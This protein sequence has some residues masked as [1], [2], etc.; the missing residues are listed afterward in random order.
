MGR[1][2]YQTCHFFTGL[3]FERKSPMRIFRGAIAPATGRLTIL[4]PL[5]LAGLI[6]ASDAQYNWTGTGGNNKWSNASNWDISG[7]PSSSADTTLDFFGT[8]TSADNDISDPFT[9]NS[10]S[11]DVTS[12]VF[13]VSGGALNFVTDSSSDLPTLNQNSK[14]AI[15]ISNN[16]TLTDSLTL[17]GPGTGTVTLS[18]VI[19]GP[20]SLI[21]SANA[22]VNPNTWVA[23]TPD[24]G[25]FTTIISNSGNTYSGGTYIAGGVVKLGADNALP[26]A[27][28][29]NVD[30]TVAGTEADSTLDLNG[31]NQTVNNINLGDVVN[32][33]SLYATTIM[34]S[35][36]GSKGTLTLNGNIQFDGG[37]QT[38]AP[39][40]VIS[41]N[42]ALSSGL[43]DITNPN[44]DVGQTGYDVVISGL[45][46]GAG[47]LTTTGGTIVAL[48]HASNQF[49]G[50]VD[51]ENSTL[52]LDAANTVSTK[53]AV[54]IGPGGDLYL[55][56]PNDSTP[57]TGTTFGSGF[58]QSIGSLTSGPHSAGLGPT[59]DLYLGAAVLTIGS[60]NTNTTF[61]G[62]ISDNDGETSDP[63]VVGGSIV[64]VGTGTLTLSGA[65]SNPNDNSDPYT[66]STTVQNGTLEVGAA[67]A[68][69]PTTS[70]IM[71]G[72]SFLTG[73]FSDT[74]GNITNGSATNSGGNVVISSGG[75]LTASNVTNT[76]GNLVVVGGG[77]LTV[78]G[79]YAQSGGVSQ[80]DGKLTLRNS[81]TLLLT[82]G[83]LAGT[84]SIVS[85]VAT[86]SVTINNTQGLVNPGDLLAVSV[87]STGSVTTSAVS[88]PGTLT[89]KGNY[90][91]GANGTLQIDLGGTAQG[92]SY[93]LLSVLDKASLAGTLNVNLTNNFAPTVGETFDFLTYG[94]LAS[95]TFANIDS[96]DAG[97]TYD[98]SYNTTTKV[99]ILTV[100]TVGVPESSTLISAGLMFGSGCLVFLS[101][102]RK[103]RSRMS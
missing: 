50:V 47:G 68:L 102:R 101:R 61:N 51:V 32:E 87:S 69:P 60:D 81:S 53:N 57:Q 79:T 99:G 70:L 46:S 20:G 18:G 15:S 6:T 9:V 33:N 86:G 17:S 88:T 71:Q 64:K 19:S 80:I 91:Q 29:P 90:T 67:G 10:V 35:S 26:A 98:I 13:N 75:A 41:S 31:H 58:N 55:Y 30:L 39:A 100:L 63:S 74:I 84:G 1:L 7:P 12:S 78:P 40:A 36:S 44:G 25:A 52:Y 76:A 49:T 85:T 97:Y 93:S 5:L 89:V 24:P 28:S 48:S 14:T 62:L 103:S 54:T 94:S 16:L 95:T 3:L 27:S 21:I 43:H 83:Q 92:T 42:L 22:T 65:N 23:G 38:I 56:V 2:G 77:A 73:A 4:L 11:F 34:D 66:G 37:S 45:I 59:I 96:L 72:G 8:A 82:G